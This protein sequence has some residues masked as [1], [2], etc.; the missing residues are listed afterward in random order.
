M[1]N[2]ALNGFLSP[3]QRVRLLEAVNKRCSVRAFSEGPNVAAK[4]ALQYAAGRLTLPGVRILV[5]EAAPEKLYRTLPGVG[6]IKGTKTY[7]AI[8]A[9]DSIARAPLH[10]GICGEAFVLEAVSL[11]LGTCWVG[12]FKESG[13]EHLLLKEGERVAA[14]IAVGVPAQEYQRRKRKPLSKI[15]VGDPASWPLWAYH[16][17]EC[18][19]YAPS[20]LNRQPWRLGYAGRTLVLEKGG[21]GSGVDLG[22]ALLHMSLGVGDK[23]HVIRWGEGKEIA[24]ILAE[25]RSL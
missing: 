22:I 21:M 9:D 2:C 4:S 16:A 25:D 3:A 12:S 14:V 6:R 19:R 23:P 24:S 17:A 18:V 11:G 15:C 5:E 20:A 7:A 8:I 10:A 13:V 1:D